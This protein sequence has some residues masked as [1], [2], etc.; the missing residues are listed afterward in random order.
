[1]KAKSKSYKLS[2]LKGDD[3]HNYKN[4]EMIECDTTPFSIVSHDG[5]SYNVKFVDR[6]SGYI[7]MYWIPDLKAASI[8][9]CFINFKTKMEI[10]IG[11]KIKYFRCDGGSEFRGVF[12]VYLNSNGIIHQVGNAYKK[13]YP[14]RA[15]RAHRTI[16]NLAKAA[17]IES[18]LPIHYFSEAHR[19]AAFTI[20]RLV[21]TG[22]DKSPIE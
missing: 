13:H 21:R 14:P 10:I 7:E 11:E 4:L 19:Y 9:N 12:E 2:K 17:H 5:Y 1:M 3:K 18:N 15:E 20:N 6:A 16:L 22:S 8:L